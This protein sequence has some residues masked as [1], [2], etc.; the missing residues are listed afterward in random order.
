MSRS[1]RLSVVAL[2]LLTAGCGGGRIP[3][4]VVAT[5][6]ENLLERQVGVRP[7]IVCPDDVPAEPGATTRCVLSAGGD[8]T[9]YGVTV[10]LVRAKDGSLTEEVQVD[11]KPLK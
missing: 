4:E 11:G 3:A 5:E 2:V 10:K 9:R 8:P 6:A 7:Q 1:V